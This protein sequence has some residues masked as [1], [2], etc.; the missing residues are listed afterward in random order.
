MFDSPILA[1]TLNLVLALVSWRLRWLTLGGSLVATMVG[2]ITFWFTGLGGWLLLMLFFLSANILSKISAVAK[3]NMVKDLHKK[4]RHRDW[5]QVVANGAL[6]AASALLYGAGG[7]RL[8]LVMFGSAIASATSDTWSSEIGLLSHK[9]PI[10]IVTGKRVPAG[11]SGGVTLLGLFGGLIGSLLI[12]VAWYGTFGQLSDSTWF[13]CAS[14]V[15]AAGFF[16]TLVDSVLGA[17][18]QGHYWDP[19][20]KLITEH[21]RRGELTF[22]LCRGIRWIDNDVVNFLSALFAL[23]FGSL[24]TVLLH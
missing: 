17:T 15:G 9:D 8:A 7:S 6:A 20:R 12:A 14:A 4:G 10:S 18:L 1:I 2:V 3:P 21:D 22:E 5:A 13:M 19:E 11:Q 23:L 24:L 16:G